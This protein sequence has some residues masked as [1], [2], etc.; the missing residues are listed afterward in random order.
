MIHCKNT[1]VLALQSTWGKMQIITHK[2]CKYLRDSVEEQSDLR[3][4]NASKI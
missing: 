1:P 3:S 4:L 2:G